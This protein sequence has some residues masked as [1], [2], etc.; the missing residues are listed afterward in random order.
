MSAASKHTRARADQKRRWTSNK[1]AAMSYKP[2]RKRRGQ[3]LSLLPWKKTLMNLP[4]TKEETMTLPLLTSRLPLAREQE[5]TIR[6]IP[7][8]INTNNKIV[9]IF[10]AIGLINYFCWWSF[11]IGN[12]PSI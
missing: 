3:T 5:R 1:E 2:W 4:L 11:Y 8:T 6:I 12:I 10:L 7:L 9:N